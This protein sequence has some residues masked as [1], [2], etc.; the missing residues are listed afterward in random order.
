[1]S[2]ISVATSGPVGDWNVCLVQGFP[3]ALGIVEDGEHWTMP[4]LANGDFEDDTVQVTFFLVM[5][6]PL[7]LFSQP[8]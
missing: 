3:A 2:Y 5:L 6:L 1:M 8:S 7:L 4:N